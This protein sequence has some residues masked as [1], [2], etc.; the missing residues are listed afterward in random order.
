MRHLHDAFKFMEHV[1]PHKS[2]KLF[3]RLYDKDTSSERKEQAA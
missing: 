2:F 1:F 3:A